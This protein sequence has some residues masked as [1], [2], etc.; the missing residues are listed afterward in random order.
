MTPRLLVDVISHIIK[1]KLT[2]LLNMISLCY[3]AWSHYIIKHDLTV[4]IET[5]AAAGATSDKNVFERVTY[6]TA[7]IFGAIGHLSVLCYCRISRVSLVQRGVG[8]LQI[9]YLPRDQNTRKHPLVYFILIV[10]IP[11]WLIGCCCDR[12]VKIAQHQ[13]C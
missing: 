12:N 13:K 3:W 6:Y 5:V 4:I 10:P 1:L 7:G 11:R 9:A 8:S 2:K